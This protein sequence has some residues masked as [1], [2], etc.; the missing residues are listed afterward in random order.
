M[1]GFS[2][3]HPVS[4]VGCMENQEFGIGNRK[5]EKNRNLTKDISLSPLVRPPAIAHCKNRYLCPW[6]MVANQKQ[7]QQTVFCSH[8]FYLVLL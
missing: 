8:S 3:L 5:T 2:Y 4:S 1:L 6:R 7:K